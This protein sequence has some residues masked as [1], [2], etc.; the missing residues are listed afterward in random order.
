MYIVRERLCMY[1]CMSVCGVGGDTD[2][3]LEEACEQLGHGRVHGG[4]IGL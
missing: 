2:Q 4:Y 1:V 3:A